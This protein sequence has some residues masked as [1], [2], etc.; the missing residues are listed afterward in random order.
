M[1]IKLN[2]VRVDFLNGFEAREFTKG[3]GKPRRS[4]TFLLEPRSDQD[5]AVQKTILEVGKEKHKEK[6]A[7]IYEGLK[8][9]SQK[10]CYVDGDTKTSDRH[11]GYMVLSA[12]RSAKEGL[13]GIYDNV[14]DPETGKVAVLPPNTSRIY[15][16]CYVNATVDI[17][18]QEGDFPGVR[19]T[20]IAVQYAGEGDAFSSSR[21]SA[22]DFEA[23]DGAG[24][25]DIT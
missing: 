12:H 9:N 17:W 18:I 4:A 14:K 7:K 22:D 13:P 24:A 20:L 10:C 2:R 1:K 5:K 6:W 8:S 15:D 19:A 25:E 16:G 3:D 23:E 11:A 21:P